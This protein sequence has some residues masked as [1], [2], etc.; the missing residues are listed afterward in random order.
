VRGLEDEMKATKS[1]ANANA[2]IAGAKEALLS[3]GQAL[4]SN[5][6]ASFERI[7]DDVDF[8]KAQTCPGSI[9]GRTRS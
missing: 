2:K 4:Y 5:A 9:G 8:R 6:P 1:S 7:D 3:L